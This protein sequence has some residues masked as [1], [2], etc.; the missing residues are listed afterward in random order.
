MGQLKYSCTICGKSYSNANN[1]EGHMAVHTKRKLFWCPICRADFVY[2]QCFK[3]HLKQKHEL[4]DEL[5]LTDFFV[6]KSD[7][8]AWEKGIYM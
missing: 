3:V 7:R 2:K 4:T 6:D 1:L 8:I 5:H